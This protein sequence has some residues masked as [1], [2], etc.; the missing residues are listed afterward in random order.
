VAEPEIDMFYP[1]IAFLETD[2]TTATKV[3]AAVWAYL[4]LN[5]AEN[6]H[7]LY[8]IRAALVGAGFEVVPRGDVPD[9]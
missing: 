8:D 1:D 5:G 7:S 2:G 4:T 3:K 6:G 9:A